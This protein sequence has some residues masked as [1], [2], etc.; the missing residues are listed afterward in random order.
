MKTKPFNLEEALNGAKVVTRD[1][2]DVTQLTKFN[3]DEIHCI[4]A[5]IDKSVKKFD[6]DGYEH[7]V[8]KRSLPTL[9]MEVEPKR[10]WINLCRDLVTDKLYIETFTSAYLSNEAIQHIKNHPN[11]EYIKT[12]E[13]TDEP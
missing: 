6:I 13:I 12:I 11:L 10:I 4:Y 5:V 8:T 1:G 7:Y 3:T 2:R 9:L